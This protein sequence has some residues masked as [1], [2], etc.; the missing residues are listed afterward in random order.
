MAVALPAVAGFE[1]GQ[2]RVVHT[3][4]VHP[5]DQRLPTAPGAVIA[6]VVEAREEGVGTRVGRVVV[7]AGGLEGGDVS[8]RHDVVRHVDV[9]GVRADVR[10]ALVGL[11]AR[12]VV[13]PDV[14]GRVVD[15]SVE[16]FKNPDCL[17]SR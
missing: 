5:V 11:V 4:G 16:G 8:A 1:G 2:G 17:H 14:D 6:V 7:G 10:A 9:R 12:V 3:A 13:D 15:E